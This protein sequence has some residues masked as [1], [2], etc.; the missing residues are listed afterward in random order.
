MKTYSK[1]CDAADWFRP[2]I[3][4]IIKREL[5]EIPRFHRKQ[6][7]SAMIFHVLHE[8]G[9]LQPQALGLSMGGGKELIAYAI[10]PHVNQLCIT[11]LYRTNRFRLKTPSSLR[12]EWICGI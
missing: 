9:G 2:E 6:W 4:A 7:E 1:L 11:D 3:D 5:R 12:S 10:A 8:H